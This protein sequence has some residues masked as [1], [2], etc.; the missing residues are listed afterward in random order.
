[1]GN[2]TNTQRP[3]GPV[4][5]G[6]LGQ[7][8]AGRQRQREV[9]PPADLG[10]LDP[11][12][13][14][15]GQPGD[16]VRGLRAGQPGVAGQPGALL[17]REPLQR[18]GSWRD[19]D[20][21]AVGGLSGHL[22]AERGAEEAVTGR[23]EL[24][25]DPPPGAAQLPGRHRPGRHRARRAPQLLPDPG[26]QAQRGS[27]RARRARCGVAARR[28]GRLAEQ[29]GRRGDPGQHLGSGERGDR[30]HPGPRVAEPGQRQSLPARLDG[31]RMQHQG[32]AVPQPGGE[33]GD[34]RRDTQRG[35]TRSGLAGHVGQEGQAGDTARNPGTGRRQV[36]VGGVEHDGG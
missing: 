13:A 1:M 33:P 15:T 9:A 11:Q 2:R 26:H 8:P 10:R 19:R 22:P 21:H 36:P 20:R 4:I 3:P 6:D 31:H 5:S 35:V 17:D 23:A 29:A 25:G 14:A 27:G 30:G 24:D 34:G 18:D 16:Q 12:R 32:A 28:G 7:R